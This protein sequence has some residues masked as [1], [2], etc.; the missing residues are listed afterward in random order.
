M[1][2][3]FVL[4]EDQVTTKSPAQWLVLAETNME[5]GLRSRYDVFDVLNLSNS[6]ISIINVSRMR[7]R[8]S[9]VWIVLARL[10]GLRTETWEE[11]TLRALARGSA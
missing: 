8:I 5:S 9:L 11:W 4:H 10:G 2:S 6:G 1:R 7:D 3:D